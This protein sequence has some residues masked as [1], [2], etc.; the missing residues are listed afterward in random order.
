[1]PAFSPPPLLS[2]KNFVK[3]AKIRVKTIAK[4]INILVH[5]IFL[6]TLFKKTLFCRSLLFRYVHVRYNIVNLEICPV[7]EKFPIKNCNN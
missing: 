7:S 6:K 3:Y 1:M 4:R 5:V 2:P